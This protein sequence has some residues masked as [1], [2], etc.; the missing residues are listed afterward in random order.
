MV[1]TVSTQQYTV[2]ILY[3]PS[4]KPLRFRSWFEGQSVEDDAINRFMDGHGLILFFKKGKDVY[5]AGE[6]SRL[7]FARMKN[8]DDE[9]S[10]A[11]E[12]E[13]SFTA[14]NL[15]AMA[16]GTPA[17]NIFTSSDLKKIKVVDRED[18]VK[19]MKKKLAEPPEKTTAVAIIKL[20]KRD[21]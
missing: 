20:S 7:A 1:Y 16:G 15:S 9:D 12:D 18:V 10:D 6:D 2:R 19:E 21:R 8:P 5:G 17:H 3:T 14:H 13:G 11:W 4:R